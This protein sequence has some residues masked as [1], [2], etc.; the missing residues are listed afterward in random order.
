M[1]GLI[2]IRSDIY[3]CLALS[4]FLVGCGN[5]DEDKTPSGEDITNRFFENLSG[6]CQQY[7]GS[8]F[9][10]VNDIK[11]SLLFTGQITISSSGDQ[12]VIQSNSIPNHDFNDNTAAFAHVVQEQGVNYSFSASP[13]IQGTSTA[14]SIGMS[15]AILLNGV[16]LDL[17]AAACYGVGNEKT[18]CGQSQ[19]NN[20]WR[21][22]PMSPLNSFGTDKH[23]AHVQPSGAYHY[24]GNPMAMFNQDCVG[25]Q[26]SPVIGFAADGFPIYGSCFTD[27]TTGVVRK[28]TSSYELKAGPRVDDGAYTAPTVGGNV[29]SANYDGQF[30]GDWQY[31]VA[32]G[33]LDECNGMTLNGQYGYYITDTFPWV[34]NCFK[35]TPNSSF[36]RMSAAR[37]HSHEP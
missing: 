7:I 12:C 1:V 33:D 13:V 26:A 14:L 31:T 5:D 9:S 8:F 4:V 18:G 23:N 27:S 36:G 24:H 16:K 28:A 19:I 17:L 2:M 34:M 11:R 3:T 29:V 10:S 6:D 22:D 15:E 30:R 32:L 21:Y 20:P 35:G 37:S 25:K